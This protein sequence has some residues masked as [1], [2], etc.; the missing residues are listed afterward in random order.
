M[1]LGMLLRL[2]RLMNLILIISKPIGIQERESSIGDLEGRK[3]GD[4]GKGDGGW[5]VGGRGS[6]VRRKKNV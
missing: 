2:V 3:M 5:E 4:F 1:T 6:G